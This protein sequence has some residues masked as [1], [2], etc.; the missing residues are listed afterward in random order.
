MTCHKDEL[1]K[2]H[3]SE[4]DKK[5]RVRGFVRARRECSSNESEWK[6]SESDEM[7]FQLNQ[8]MKAL[9][10]HVERAKRWNK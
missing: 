5:K 10:L 8:F 7:N 3:S 6:G 4:S 1:I 2:N 9:S